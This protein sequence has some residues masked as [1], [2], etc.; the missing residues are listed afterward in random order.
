MPIS[1]SSFGDIVAVLQIAWQLRAALSDASGASAEIRALL[2]DIDSFTR[3]LQQT[4]AAIERRRTPPAPS[5]EHGI[6]HAVIACHDVLRLIVGKVDAFKRRMT[7]RIG[8]VAWRQYW[9]VAAWSILGG[10]KEVDGLRVRLS[11]QIGVIQTYLSLAQSNDQEKVQ[12]TVE[13][14]GTTLDL[15]CSVMQDIQIR[16]DVGV[17]S[18]HFCGW[19][20]NYYPPL[21]R[22]SFQRFME[23]FERVG[24][25]GRL[26]DL[27]IDESTNQLLYTDEYLHNIC[28]AKSPFVAEFT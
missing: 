25:S 9:A 15:I 13:S 22:T 10:K 24:C 20:G 8:A 3:A 27:K 17:P 16:F 18:F 23:L 7:S 6:K 21:A 12:E 11:E 19:G 28:V 5:V 26:R 2:I 1:F 14:H 4:K